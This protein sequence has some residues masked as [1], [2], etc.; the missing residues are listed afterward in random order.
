M[1]TDI[2]RLRRLNELV[3]ISLKRKHITVLDPKEKVEG[4]EK[5]SEGIIYD[6]ADWKIS[7]ELKAY[8]DE[9]AQNDKLSTEDKILLI[10]EKLCKDYVYD[11][12]LISYIKKVDE[13]SYS[14]PDWYGRDID[15]EWE[16]N[17]QKHNRRICFELSR[18]LAKAL[19]ELLKDDQS[20]DVCIFWDK[21]LTHYFVGLTCGEYSVDLDLDNFFNIKDLTRL[22]TDL[23]AEG[24]N[25][26]V[27]DS[28]KFKK[29]LDKFN[30][31]KEK[32][33]IIK[34][35]SDISQREEQEH[36]TDETKFE[37]EDVE[38]LNEAI[39]V[40][41]EQYDVDSQGIY[42]Y[43][44]EIVDIRLDPK[45]RKKLWKRIDGES[46]ESLR[47][48][49]CLCVNINGKDYLIDVDKKLIRP[50][51]REELNQKRT[52]FV[53]YSELSRGSYEFYDGK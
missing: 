3:N 37:D 6:K 23:T 34:M 38:F 30:E 41:A 5:D 7:D 46:R 39:K 51:D 28:G 29:A 25:I 19:K 31:G 49:R 1:N 35:E 32:F 10:Y 22:K 24:I 26:L 15:S 48:I 20:Y 42:E 2:K 33:A 21:D 8:I 40:L 27:D 14:L 50:F 47:Y 36:E 53:E 4:V 16:E 9:L 13:D 44:K 43:M 12:N 18:Y 52:S 17:R 11:D 45:S